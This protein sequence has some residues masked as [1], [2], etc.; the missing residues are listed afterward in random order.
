MRK[1]MCQ[2]G[3]QPL[4]ATEKYGEV[5]RDQNFIVFFC[6]GYDIILFSENYTGTF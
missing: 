1:G 2:P 4:T 3:Q 5:G 6:S